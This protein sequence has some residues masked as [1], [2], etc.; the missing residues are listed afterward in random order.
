MVVILM[1]MVFFVGVVV[2]V[3]VGLIWRK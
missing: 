3:Q 1:I 2:G